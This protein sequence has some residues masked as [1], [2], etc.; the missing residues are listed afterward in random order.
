M[1]FSHL[2][3]RLVA[4]TAAATAVAA[5]VL[6]AGAAGRTPVPPR[7]GH[8]FVVDLENKGYDET[9]G[10]TA[11]PY[12]A[13]VLPSQGALLTQYY[14][15]GHA[16]LDNYITQVSGQAPNM[17][18]QADCQRYVDLLPGTPLPDGSGQVTGQGC[19]YPA[20]VQTLPD[21]LM[22]AGRTWRG[23]MEDLGADPTREKKTC[24]NPGSSA[25]PGTQDPTQV[26]TAK[27]QYAARHNPFP[28]FHSLVDSGA[29][30]EHVGSLDRLPG[31]LR[32]TA[33]TPTFS[34]ITPDL[35]SDGHDTNCVDGRPGGLTS[36]NDFLRIWV[37]R[38]TSS[39]AFR[40][41]GLLVIT[42]DESEANDAGSCCGAPSGPNTPA[43][44]ISGPG[45]GRVGAVLLSPYIEPGTRSD[46]AYDHYSALRSY[47]DL[48]G[49][50][51]GGTDGK[52]HLGYA[53]RAG[54]RTF[55]AD[56]F[57]ARRR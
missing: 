45:G 4:L 8:L 46:V 35:C 50:R 24:G 38:I 34:W 47:E 17:Y 1:S 30:D 57:T 55:G 19:V 18:T 2:S 33:T 15:T 28:Y 39:P 3:R 7:I 27:D 29:C 10:A 52:G 32:G 43:P 40:K 42:F 51:T 12:L 21:Q 25:A 41:D 53:A 22:T 54:L 37:P 56:V 20:S 36:I 13:K 23:Y 11:P 6:P 5:T 44:G 16:S 49:I 31:D 9:F 14:A 26:A 48:L